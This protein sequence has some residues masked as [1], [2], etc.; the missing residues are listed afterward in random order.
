MDRKVNTQ[1]TRQIHRETIINVDF[2]QIDKHEQIDK[3][4]QTEMNKKKKK[5]KKEKGGQGQI[6]KWIRHIDKKKKR[7]KKKKREIVVYG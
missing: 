7:T 4:I 2:T 6:D 5:G 1:R 3:S